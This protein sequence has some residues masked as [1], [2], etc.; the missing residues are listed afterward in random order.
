[1]FVL[2]GLPPDAMADDHNSSDVEMNADDKA[3]PSKESGLRKPA[4]KWDTLSRRLLMSQVGGSVGD[5]VDVLGNM[6]DLLD[7]TW[8]TCWVQYA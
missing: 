1:M 6:V 8:L 4:L 7:T 5:T 3:T 2:A